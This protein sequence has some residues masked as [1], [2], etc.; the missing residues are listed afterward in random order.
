M[1][2]RE[3]VSRLPHT[4]DGVPIIPHEHP[5]VFVFSRRKGLYRPG[6]KADWWE[7]RIDSFDGEDFV[8]FVAGSHMARFKPGECYASVEVAMA[9][10]AST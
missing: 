8:G 10:G 1:S 6:E 9:A 7:M 4:A 3:I 5:I 2:D